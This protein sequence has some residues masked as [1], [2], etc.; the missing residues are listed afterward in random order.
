MTAPKSFKARQRD[1]RELEILQMAGHI[2]RERGYSNLSMD[3]LAEA[4]GISKPTLYQ[5]F[6]SKEEIVVSATLKAALEMETFVTQLEGQRRT[7]LDK[8]EA[9][10]RFMLDSMTSPTAF[11]SM[12]VSEVAM[13]V[14]EE[15]PDALRPMQECQTLLYGWVV[16]GQLQGLI[17]PALSPIVVIGTL[18]SLLAV[19]DPSR[20]NPIHELDKAALIEE[21]VLV[22]KRGVGLG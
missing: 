15:H 18:F 11:P 20:K 10:L 8:L 16:E 14:M 7:P 1:Q 21:V 22:F 12:M 5:H 9:M 3:A 2:I 17:H 19:L 6:K 13:Q 4:V